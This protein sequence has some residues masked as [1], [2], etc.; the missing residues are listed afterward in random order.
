MKQQRLTGYRPA[1][2]R[3][4]LQGAAITGLALVAMGGLA[5]CA[6]VRQPELQ[7][8]GVALVTEPPEE[9]LVL[10]GEVAIVEPEPTPEM[11]LQTTGVL[12]A[13]TATPEA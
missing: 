8:S 1:Y 3:K 5:G 2:P 6:K 7:T 13:P 11:P 9:E 4:A 12:L 10:D